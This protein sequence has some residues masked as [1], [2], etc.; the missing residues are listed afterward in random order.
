MTVPVT[1][2]FLDVGGVLLTNGW[3]EPIRRRAAAKFALDFTE[4]EHRHHLNY[5]THEAGKLSLDDYLKRVVF[6]APRAFPPAEFKAFMCAQSQPFPEMLEFVRALKARHR[7]KIAVV[8]NEGRELTAYRIQTFKLAEF[9]DC[10]IASC[11]VHLRKPD[12]D[13]YRLALDAAQASPGEAVYIDDR[14]LFVEVA[15]G[16]G[17]R[18]IS[19]TDCAATRKTLAEWGLAL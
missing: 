17:V 4:M 2:L 15:R 1:T 7:L 5:E 11:F 19:H 10:F 12:E 6:H 13:I 16:L 8:S 3:D 18:G 9:V 14:A